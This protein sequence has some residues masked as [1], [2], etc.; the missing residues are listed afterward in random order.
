MLVLH[1]FS[2]VESVEVSIESLCHDGINVGLAGLGTAVQLECLV[3]LLVCG[4]KLKL[5]WLIVSH[6]ELRNGR[7]CTWLAKS[8]D[9]V[10]VFLK[11]SHLFLREVTL[12]G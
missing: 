4:L 12:I 5:L 8:L 10:L 6:T 11:L 2:L 1:K 9:H 3:S 7:S